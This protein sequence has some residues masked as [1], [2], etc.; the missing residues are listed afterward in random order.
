MKKTLLFVI[1]ACLVNFTAF[2]Q[3]SMPTSKAPGQPYNPN[4]YPAL[5][6]GGENIASAVAIAS[7]PFVDNGTTCG[8]LDDYAANCGCCGGSSGAPDLVYSFVADHDGSVNISVNGDYDSFVHV[9]DIGNNIVGCDDDS[10]GDFQAYIAAMPVI[11]GATYYVVV[12][13]YS[14]NCGN[15]TVNVSSV[16]VVPSQ[17][18]LAPWIIGL[19]SLLILTAAVL[20]YQK[21]I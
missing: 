14:S 20:R 18:P 13:G 12:E 21:V 16:N 1:L 4:D 5:R 11:E 17:T 6:A 19:A 8:A 10:G 2:A 15:Y 7:L 3:E 9:R